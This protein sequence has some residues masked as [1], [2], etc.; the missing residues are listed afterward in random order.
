MA[1][2]VLQILNRSSPPAHATRRCPAAPQAKGAVGR[3]FTE[4]TARSSGG[5]NSSPGGAR[6]AG[7]PPPP[8][9]RGGPGAGGGESSGGAAARRRS[10]AGG[11]AA[12]LPLSTVRAATRRA[13]CRGPLRTP[14]V[15]WPPAHAPPPPALDNHPA[16]APPPIPGPTPQLLPTLEGFD[17]EAYLSVF[18]EATPADDLAAGLTSLERELGERQGQLKTL[19]GGPAGAGSGRG[20]ER[21]GWKQVALGK[22]EG[23]QRLT[24]SP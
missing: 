24:R 9:A 16:L 23:R 12:G 19:V 17:P 13:T 14:P 2:R 6:A 20:L 11:R 18:H 5:R 10:L 22:A 4:L 3:F 15:P 1:A 7:A 21:A 8:G